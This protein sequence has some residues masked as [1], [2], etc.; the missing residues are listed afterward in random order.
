MI[1]SISSGGSAGLA[2]LKAKVAVQ[3]HEPPINV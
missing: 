3:I 2:E 1:S